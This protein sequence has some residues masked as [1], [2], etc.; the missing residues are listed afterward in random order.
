MFVTWTK[1]VPSHKL[2]LDGSVENQETISWRSQI[3]HFLVIII[4]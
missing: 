2:S 3:P 4:G 1:Y